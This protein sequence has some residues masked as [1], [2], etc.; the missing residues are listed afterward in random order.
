MRLLI[1]ENGEE[2]DLKEG[3]FKEIKRYLLNQL[4][5]LTDWMEEEGN[6]WSNFKET[7]N[8][9]K[10]NVVEATNSYEINKALNELNNKISWWGIYII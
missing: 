3:N 8:E 2:R 7:R 10:R 1:K 5:C 4:N 6:E 9:I